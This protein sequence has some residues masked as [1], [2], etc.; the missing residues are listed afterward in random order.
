MLTVARRAPVLAMLVVVLVPSGT[1]AATRNVSIVDFAFD[2]AAMQVRL[3]TTVQWTNNG[4]FLHTS[5]SDDAAHQNP[6]GFPG[7]GWWN[8]GNLVAGGVGTFSWDFT[9]AG[10]FTY[11]C[12]RHPATMTGR[13]NVPVRVRQVETSTGTA[14]RI[15]WAIE[16][17]SDPELSF[18]VQKK[19]PGGVFADWKASTTTLRALFRPSQAG[20][21]QF[22]AR[23]IRSSGGTITGASLYSPVASLVAS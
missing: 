1:M 17:P 3:G 13:V 23:L 14:Y 18:N 12:Q 22:R 15:T 7:P 2:P 8:S 19:N 5:T 11:Y 4:Q 16:A 10:G 6:Q 21:Y 9:A 20:T